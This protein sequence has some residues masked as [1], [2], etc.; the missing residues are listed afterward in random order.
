MVDDDVVVVVG[1]VASFSTVARKMDR[2]ASRRR[3]DDK[4][5]GRKA[6]KGN[7]A[8]T[9]KMA[10]SLMDRINLMSDCCDAMRIMLWP[11]YRKGPMI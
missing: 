3:D 5:D 11:I 6:V 8:A 4:E 10:T 2:K 1:V 9:S 7:A